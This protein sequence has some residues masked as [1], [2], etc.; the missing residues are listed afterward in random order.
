MLELVKPQTLRS[1]LSMTPASNVGETFAGNWLAFAGYAVAV[2]ISVG[3]VGLA[4]ACSSEDKSEFCCGS[5]TEYAV[6]LMK[7]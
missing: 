1:R 7:G 6:E 3:T 5:R 4:H 2:P